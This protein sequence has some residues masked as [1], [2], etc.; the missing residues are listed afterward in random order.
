M[1]TGASRAYNSVLHLA[2]VAFTVALVWFAFGYYPQ[3]IENYKTG[4]FPKKPILPAAVASSYKFP[5]ETT[6]YRVIWEEQS[7][8][9]YAFINGQTLEEYLVNRDGAKLAVKT[10]LSLNSL[11]GVNVLYVSVEELTIPARFQND[12]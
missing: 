10:A 8:T 6:S 1:G 7:G 11:C 2:I 5:I 12:C 4:N 3:V 9:Y